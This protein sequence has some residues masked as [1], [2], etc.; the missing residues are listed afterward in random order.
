MVIFYMLDTLTIHHL[1]GLGILF[2]LFDPAVPLEVSMTGFE[3]G[4]IVLPCTHSG[5]NVSVTLL[6]KD[7]TF[8]WRFKEVKNVYNHINGKDDLLNQDPQFK[9]RTTLIDPQK[10]DFSLKLTH[11][12]EKD[13]GT[14][15]CVVPRIETDYHSQR[16]SLTIKENFNQET[17]KDP[18][19]GCI[20]RGPRMLVFLLIFMLRV[21]AE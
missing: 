20:K 15:K 1:T 6:E 7:M 19:N 4:D 14:Y 2:V 5:P 17:R 12:T 10:G 16:V 18:E 11:L 9:N 3:G 21:L 13:S 8:T